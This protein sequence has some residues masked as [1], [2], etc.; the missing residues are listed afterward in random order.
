MSF[1]NPD[2]GTSII[3]SSLT[4]ALRGRSINDRLAYLKQTNLNP[5]TRETPIRL[6]NSMALTVRNEQPDLQM[7]ATYVV[8]E[9]AHFQIGVSSFHWTIEQ[10]TDYP[11]YR[12]LLESFT[13]SK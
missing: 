7:E 11:A 13:V 8:T 9:S 5:Q 10:L 4:D 12:H 6:G 1:F 3:V 2:T